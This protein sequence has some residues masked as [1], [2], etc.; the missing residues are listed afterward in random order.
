MFT[1]CQNFFKPV[2][3]TVT[4]LSNWI[5]SNINGEVITRNNPEIK[6]SDEIAI[7]CVHGIADRC[8]AFSALVKRLLP[9]LS[10]QVTHIELVSFKKRARG[11][12]II[13]YA[14]QLKNL[15]E[16]RPFKNIIIMGHSRG[17][18]VAAYFVEN[19][20]KEINVNT[21]EVICISSPLRGSDLV[22]FPLSIIPSSISEMKPDSSFLQTLTMKIKQSSTQYLYFI[23]DR[24]WLVDTTQACINDEIHL[25]H[26]KVLDNHNHLSIMTSKRLASHIQDSI[27]QIITQHKHI[28][29]ASL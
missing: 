26:L 21:L 13:N 2:S 6:Q 7:Y 25:Q 17:G 10:P 8:S 28:P 1:A 16:S 18:L 5:I 9:I 22:I 4:H 15:I 23:G 24:D 20:A 14:E 29:T 11:Q 27:D 19:M 12:S 3:G